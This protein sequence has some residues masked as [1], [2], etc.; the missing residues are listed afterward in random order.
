MPYSLIGRILYAVP[1]FVFGLGHLTAAASYTPM[2]PAWLPGGVLWVYLT[3]V[4]LIAAAVAIASKK[5]AFEASLCL[6]ALLL[7]F[8]VTVHLPNML[9]GEGMLKV[10]GMVSFFK[11]F[12]LSGAALFIAGHS[13]A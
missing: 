1:M 6:S 13:K 9:N 8:A 2:V 12:A 7:V 11:D 5:M 10:M 4:A 3:G